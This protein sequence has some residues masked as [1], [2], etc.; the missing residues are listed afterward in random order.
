M[1]QMPVHLCSGVFI[2]WFAAIIYV[3]KKVFSGHIMN[4]L[5]IPTAFDKEKLNDVFLVT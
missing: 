3:A 4:F 5:S 1:K 2:F